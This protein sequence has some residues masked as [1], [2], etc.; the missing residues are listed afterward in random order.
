[1]AGLCIWRGAFRQSLDT[2][3][4]PRLGN[5]SRPLPVLGNMKQKPQ[6]LA[7]SVV[8]LCACSIHGS[9]VVVRGDHYAVARY[10]DSGDSLK[11]EALQE[12]SGYCAKK[13]Q[14]LNVI[15]S[16]EIPAGEFG[17]WAES[18]VEFSCETNTALT[19]T[20]YP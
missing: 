8:L 15:H 2:P 9:G 6:L 7:M 1:M 13:Q 18:E 4:S 11:A 19:Q 14:K 10:A 12:A 16:K 5:S 3:E 17:R 20:T